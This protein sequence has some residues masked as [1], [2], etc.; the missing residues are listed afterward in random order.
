MHTTVRVALRCTIEWGLS[1]PDEY[2]LTVNSRS[3][4][5]WGKA[6]VEVYDGLKKGSCIEGKWTFLFAMI[7]HVVA[8]AKSTCR[9]SCSP[10]QLRQKEVGNINIT[11]Q[12]SIY[13]NVLHWSYHFWATL[14]IPRYFSKDWRNTQKAWI[15]VPGWDSNQIAFEFGVIVSRAINPLSFASKLS[16]VPFLYEA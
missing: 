9:R 16:S 13:F 1:R 7:E 2:R 3:L 15:R 8:P 10:E 4:E 6:V 14:Y 12:R 5:K 11:S